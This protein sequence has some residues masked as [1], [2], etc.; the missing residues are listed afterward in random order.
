[1][2][3]VNPIRGEAAENRELA[4]REYTLAA[5]K[6]LTADQLSQKYNADLGEGR[7]PLFGEVDWTYAVLNHQTLRGYW[8]WVQSQIEEELVDAVFE[9]A[10]VSLPSA[11]HHHLAGPSD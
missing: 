2:V 6:A 5:D 11:T 9:A 8:D 1:M 7:H 10:K 3:D 4:R